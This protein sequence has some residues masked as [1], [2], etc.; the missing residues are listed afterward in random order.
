LLRI[1]LKSSEQAD[2]ASLRR[3]TTSIALPLKRPKDVTAFVRI[4]QRHV[5]WAAPKS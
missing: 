5:E 2:R 4:R 1:G 3:T